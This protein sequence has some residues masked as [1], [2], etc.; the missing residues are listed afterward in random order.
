VHAQ[1]ERRGVSCAALG[2]GGEPQ[3][4]AAAKPFLSALTC[5]APQPDPVEASQLQAWYMD[6]SDDDARLPH[7]CAPF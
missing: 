3:R 2:R 5:A 4:G 7:Q 1:S 6:D